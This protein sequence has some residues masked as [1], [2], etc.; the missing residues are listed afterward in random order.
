MAT[1]THYF[2]KCG[3]ALLKKLYLKS[4]MIMHVTTT[5]KQMDLKSL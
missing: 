1:Y 3:I 4:I 2:A 5:A